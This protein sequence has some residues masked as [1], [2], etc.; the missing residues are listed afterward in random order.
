MTKIIILKR[1]KLGDLLLTTPML[2]LLRKLYPK[3]KLAVVAPESSA[4]ILKNV[5][6]IDQL[7]SYPQPKSFNLQSLAAVFI[8]LFIFLKIRLE[9]YDIAIAAGGE[10]SPRAVKR[11]VLIKAKRTISFVP[12]NKIIKEITDPVMELTQEKGRCH[13]SQRMIE[14]L[15]P[16]AQSEKKLIA[17]SVY[18]R[19]PDE[20]L[21][22]AQVFLTTHQLKK[23][24]YIV[25]GLGARREKKQASKEQIIETAIYA[26][27]K[28]K[29]KTILVWTPGSKNN[30]NYPGDDE[31]A[32]GILKS[33][34]EEIIPL[35]APLDLTIGVIWLA[36]KSIFPDSGL[37]HFASASP[38]G[39]IGL[40]ADTKVSPNPEQWGPLGLKSNYIEAKKNIKD[41]GIRFLHK[42]INR[43]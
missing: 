41:L 8:Q 15:N 17:P 33:A 10:Y 11:I 38:G 28:H 40:F 31:L 7:Y 43:L 4:W 21:R 23:G 42:E 26:F 37:M 36:K 13:E 22:K 39:V 16:I 32:Y 30:R 18:F 2:Q 6:F 1:D 12:Q 27:K 19:P 9:R 29:L 35:R 3:S 34:P 14:L 24:H 5:S 20:W 25:F